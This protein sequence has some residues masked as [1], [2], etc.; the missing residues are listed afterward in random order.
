[1][2]LNIKN[3]FVNII[4]LYYFGAQLFHVE[5]GLNVKIINYYYIMGRD[6]KIQKKI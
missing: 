5:R 6:F 3:K 2:I 1:M 4:I